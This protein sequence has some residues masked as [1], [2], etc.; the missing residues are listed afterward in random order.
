M[1]GYG[2][3]SVDKPGWI[4][5]DVP[6]CGEV[7]AIIRPIVLAPCSSDCHVMHGGAGPKEN[8]ILGHEAVGEVV[9]IGRRVKG[10]EVGDTVVVPCVTPD[11][12]SPAVQGKYNPHDEGQM[13]GFKFTSLKDGT[14]AEFF[15]VNHARANLVKLPEG[16]SPEAAL[17]TVD[18]MS[19]GFHGA[20]GAEIEFGDTVVVMGIGPV[21]LMAIAGAALGGA[22]RII[23]IGTR[24]NCIDVAYH[25][26]A[27]DIVSYKLG[28]TVDQ[29][30][31]LTKGGAD[32]VIIAGGGQESFRQAVDMTKAGGRISNI[33]FFDV[34]D[35]LSMPAATWGLGMADKTIRGGFCPGGARR[36]KRMLNMIEHGRVDT[37]KLIS[38]RYY[39]FDKIEEAFHVMDQKPRDLI[40]PVVFCDQTEPAA[41]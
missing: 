14:M 8:M 38:H 32:A 20:E 13:T 23:A 15:H 9:E 5:K 7:D 26:G 10:V 18:M 28:D 22:S 19:T 6:A 24:P 36:I 31:E 35:T 30:L 40:K 27:T 34:N 11:W 41:V 2:M 4:E 37:T 25:Y 33:N 17:M 1:R 39:G 3:L 29:V 12:M 21:G 16:V